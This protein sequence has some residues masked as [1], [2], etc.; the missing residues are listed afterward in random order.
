MN[1]SRLTKEKL[2]SK[3]DSIYL[4]NRAYLTAQKNPVF[5]T[6]LSFG[7]ESYR[8]FTFLSELHGNIEQESIRASLRTWVSKG[9]VRKTKSEGSVVKYGA[10][11][12]TIYRLTGLREALEQ[13]TGES[14]TLLLA[15]LHDESGKLLL[16]AKGG[17]MM[18]REILAGSNNPVQRLWYIRENWTRQLQSL[19]TEAGGIFT[20]DTEKADA[21]I[22]LIEQYTL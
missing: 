10:D 13:V 22:S 18:H 20:I 6:L 5:E 1:T 17:A 21:I 19:V 8:S 15:F 14:P 12:D 4:L 11:Y 7:P 9:L 16:T 3:L 2:F